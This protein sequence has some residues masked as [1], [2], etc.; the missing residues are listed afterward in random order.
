MRITKY[1]CA[2]C[3]YYTISNRSDICPVCFW[4]EDF[5][6]EDCI[7][8]DGGPNRTS[9]KKSREN[10]RKYGVMDLEFKE[11]VRLPLEEES[12]DPFGVRRSSIT[13]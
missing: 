2:C 10:Y 13:E 3:S 11:Y 5:Y 6:Q 8:D 9:L 4:Q 12:K 7:Y 1:K